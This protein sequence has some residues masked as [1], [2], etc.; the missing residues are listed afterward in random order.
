[1]GTSHQDLT[2]FAPGA[3]WLVD[4]P[5]RYAGSTFGGKMTVIRL[6][7]GKLILHSPCAIPP[8]LKAAIEA[9]GEVGWLVAPGNFHHLHI[10]AAKHAFPE[11]EIWIAPGVEKKSN[12][13][14]SM[15]ECWATTCRRHGV[16]KS[17][18]NSSAA[19]G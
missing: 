7:S 16:V 6:G 4:Y 17:N 1:M 12:R 13:H 10:A 9:I 15:T 2:E 11:A 14:W 19:T 3:V 18:S 8:E 5:V